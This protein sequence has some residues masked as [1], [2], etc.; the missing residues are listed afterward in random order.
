MKCSKAACSR[1][2]SCRILGPEAT[3]ETLTLHVAQSWYTRK[4]RP[5]Y[6]TLRE[7]SVMDTLPIRPRAVSWLSST[8]SNRSSFYNESTKNNASIINM[9]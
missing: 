6:L 4:C 8:R 7:S 5:E 2:P 3:E 1:K 9:L